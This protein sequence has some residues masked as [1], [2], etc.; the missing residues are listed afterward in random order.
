M[1]EVLRNQTLHDT[2]ALSDVLRNGALR[3]KSPPSS[4]EVSSETS[5][6]INGS[7]EVKFQFPPIPITSTA[8]LKGRAL[9]R[10]IQSIVCTQS[11]GD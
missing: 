7:L 2:N 11:L 4:R 10:K 3:V 6:V 1:S 9:Y 8:C 5:C